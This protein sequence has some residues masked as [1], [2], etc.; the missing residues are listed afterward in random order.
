MSHPE[1]DV[2]VDLATGEQ[3]DAAVTAHVTHVPTVL[4]RGLLAA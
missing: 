4:G 1:E 3:V 2:L